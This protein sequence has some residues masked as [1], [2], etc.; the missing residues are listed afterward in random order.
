MEDGRSPQ[1]YPGLQSHA[2]LLTIM[3]WD[4]INLYM[5]E[6]K[7]NDNP[8]NGKQDNSYFKFSGM[9]L[10]MIVVIGLFAFAGYKID[11]SAHHSTKW[12]TAALSLTGVFISL[13]LV[14]RS[15]KE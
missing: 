10:Q 5:V 3:Q 6:G 14:I 4:L 2:N 15:I 8:G 11:E 12:V 1:F 9:A 7:Q 13:Y